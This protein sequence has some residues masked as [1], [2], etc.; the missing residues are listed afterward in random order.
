MNHTVSVNPREKLFHLRPVFRMRERNGGGL[1]EFAPWVDVVMLSLM[2]FISATAL[3]RKPG[4]E[5]VLPEAAPNIGA[6]YDARVLTAMPDG[7]F[8]FDDQR[9]ARAGLA[10]ALSASAR[11]HQELGL[12]IE[13][14][15]ALPHQAVMDV[16]ALAV[17][18]GWTKITMATR[19]E[20]IIN[21]DVP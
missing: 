19:P 18:S 8:Y 1:L 4:V 16:Y 11:H 2:I 9:L 3:V 15:A 10:A 7:S 17:K 12:I 14:D 13:A 5:L 21:Q 6:R 20:S